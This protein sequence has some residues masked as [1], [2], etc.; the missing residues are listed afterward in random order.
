ME[1]TEKIKFFEKCIILLFTIIALSNK[2]LIKN[3]YLFKSSNLGL[4][5]SFSAGNN[6]SSVTHSS[7]G[8]SGNT[9][10]KGHDG[11]GIRSRIILRQIFG[12]LFFGLTSNF[13]D[14]DDTFGVGIVDKDV[15]TINKVSSIEGITADT[16]AKGLS[17]TNLGR[18][19]NCFVG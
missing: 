2:L 1:F 4:G 12:G 5:S 8:R 16:N 9:S 14:H 3:V 10:N 18:L 17:K 15:E 11:F 13:T 6:G 7:S 19:V